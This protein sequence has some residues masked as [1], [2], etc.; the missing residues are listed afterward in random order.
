[1]ARRARPGGGLTFL[2]EAAHVIALPLAPT[3]APQSHIRIEPR[4]AALAVNIT[5]PVEAAGECGAWLRE[6]LR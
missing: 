3:P 5:W 2:P 1:M 6:L 4:R